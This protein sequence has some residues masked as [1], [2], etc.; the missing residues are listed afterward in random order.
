[1]LKRFFPP[2]H[3]Y[4]PIPSV[5]EINKNKIFKNTPR[6][7][8]RIDLNKKEQIKLLNIFKHYYNRIAFLY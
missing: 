2:R 1:M 3:F 6:S 8:P 4:S 7:L 5:D